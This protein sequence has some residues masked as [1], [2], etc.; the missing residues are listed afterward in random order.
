MAHDIPLTKRSIKVESREVKRNGRNEQTFFP[1][2]E[3]WERQQVR[4]DQHAASF[5]ALGIGAIFGALTI[6]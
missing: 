3:D 2:Q 5:P 1:F 4:I 6:T